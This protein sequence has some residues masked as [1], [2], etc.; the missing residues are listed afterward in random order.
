M[1]DPDSLGS[2][3][4]D[5]IAEEGIENVFYDEDAEATFLEGEGELGGEERYRTDS[6]TSIAS[7]EQKQGR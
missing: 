2:Y 1:K 6:Q 4:L 5:S 7:D 3:T